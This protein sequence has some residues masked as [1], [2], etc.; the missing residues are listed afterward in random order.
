M[1][2]GQSFHFIPIHKTRKR[3]KK[4]SMN[5]QCSRECNLIL[6][7]ICLSVVPVVHLPFQ[8]HHQMKL[9]KAE[10]LK[11]FHCLPSPTNRKNESIVSTFYS[12]FQKSI[13][14]PLSRGWNGE[15]H[16]NSNILA[17][18]QFVK[19]IVL[20]MYGVLLASI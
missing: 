13:A 2:R 14:I 15:Q 4:T 3:E 18:G 8:Q 16:E 5:L 20:N 11:A 12:V 19:C 9:M 10:Y 6:S 7:T 17:Y 1:Y